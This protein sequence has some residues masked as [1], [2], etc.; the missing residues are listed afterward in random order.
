MRSP[1]WMLHE[2]AA[3]FMMCDQRQHSKSA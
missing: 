3:F 1:T 2:M